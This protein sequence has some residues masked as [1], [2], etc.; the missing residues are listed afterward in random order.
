MQAGRC[1]RCWVTVIGMDDVGTVTIVAS[2]VVVLRYY[3]I[4]RS[5]D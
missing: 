2:P 3:R 1:S 5:F 4:H